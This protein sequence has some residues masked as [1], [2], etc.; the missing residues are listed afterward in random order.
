MTCRFDSNN[1]GLEYTRQ[2]NHVLGFKTLESDI[3][4]NLQ[5]LSDKMLRCHDSAVFSLI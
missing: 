4:A 5:L 3:Y 2:V 1:V